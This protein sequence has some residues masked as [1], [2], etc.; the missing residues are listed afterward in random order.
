MKEKIEFSELFLESKTKDWITLYPTLNRKLLKR[1]IFVSDR[2]NLGRKDSNL[3]VTG[4]KPIAL[5]L[6][7]APFRFIFD[8]NKH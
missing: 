8:T 1:R 6:G 5:P 2:D 3:R 7:H 4:P